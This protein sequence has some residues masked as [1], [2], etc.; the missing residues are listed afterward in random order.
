MTAD[1]VAAVER[2][3]EVFRSY[4]PV[5]GRVV[6]CP[7]C[8][9]D[10]A[11]RH[12][13]TSPLRKLNESYLADYAESAHVFG[14]A[15]TVADFRYLLP[16]CFEAIAQGGTVHRCGLEI[17]LRRLREAGFRQ[18]WPAVEVEAAD[19]F[20]T[21]LV[22]DR[23]SRYTLIDQF[24]GTKQPID[25]VLGTIIVAGGDLPR[26]LA[27]WDAVPGDAP[28][29][30]YAD[31][32]RGLRDDDEGLALDSVWLTEHHAECLAVG[33]WLR[34]DAVIERIR[35]AFFAATDPR[36]E[37]ILSEGEAILT[38]AR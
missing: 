14:D 12:L 21:A 24:P 22:A 2:A 29:V 18:H 23:V 37:Q 11:M 36:V 5:D 35:A 15:R 20:F 10:E 38:A 32:A 27:A 3:Y 8:V 9:D 28:V 26:A 30:H 6:V 17:S 25:E 1:L 33:A 16:R 31:C 4:R 7:C 13:A 19:D 34:R